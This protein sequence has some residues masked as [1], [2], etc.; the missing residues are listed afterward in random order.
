MDPR[1]TLLACINEMPPSE[2][3]ALSKNLAALK[4]LAARLAMIAGSIFSRVLDLTG[5]GIIA[6]LVEKGGPWGYIDHRITDA[7]FPIKSDGKRTVRYRGIKGANLKRADGWVYRADV[8]AAFRKEGMRFGNPAENL[9]V[10][11]EDSEAGRGDEPMVMFV[12]GSPFAFVVYEGVG[13]ARGLSLR[14]D[15]HW[16]PS[17]V[18]VGVVVASE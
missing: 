8:E 15:G 3:E 12:E 16:G 1:E 13:G 14:G 6:R 9:L 11:A 10:P 17:C 2:Q 7:T 4:Q 5:P 18:F